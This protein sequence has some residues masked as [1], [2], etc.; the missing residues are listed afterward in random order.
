[1]NVHRLPP[2]YLQRAV[3]VLVV[4][5]GGTGSEILSGLP[6][7]HHAMLALGHPGGL[8]VAVL[9]GDV[10]SSS[11]VVRQPFTA[12]DV[13]HPK[14]TI[15][16]N[17]INTFYGLRWRA[18]TRHLAPTSAGPRQADLIIG[19]VDTR[20]ARS[21][22][23]SSLTAEEEFTQRPI[24]WL[25]LGNDAATGQFLLGQVQRARGGFAVK[26]MSP[27]RLPT[28]A[29]LYPETVDAGADGDDTRPSCSAAEAL[30]RQ[31][32]FVNRAIASLALAMLGRLFR[33]GEL[34]YHGGFVN[35]TTGQTT[36]IPVS[37]DYWASLRPRRRRRPAAM[38]ASRRVAA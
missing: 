19:C 7:L 1:M 30:T 8:D 31:E 28:V 3:R 14:A 29:E 21:A 4:G 13:G 10:V 33:Y 36:R 11:N 22:I 24:Y 15:L 5:A 18:Y 35:L 38:H 2:S 34:P 23:W 32:P 25:D 12:N 27:D 6:H 17:R 9:D 16:V 26:A 20:T 37:P